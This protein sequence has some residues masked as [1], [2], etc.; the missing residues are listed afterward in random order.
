MYRDWGKRCFDATAAAAG[1]LCLAPVMALL[2]LLVRV[3]LGSPV[4]FRQERPGLGGRGFTI[5]KFR[6]MA[7]A[8]DE[9]GAL[10]PDADRLTPFGRFLRSSS[11]DELPELINVLKGEMSLVG[12]RP[13]LVCYLVR[14]SAE[15]AR[16]HGVR[17]GITGWAQVGG[18]N[19]LGWDD[20]LARDVWYV[21]HVGLALDLSILWK[22]AGA[23]VSRRG[24]SAPGH[25]TMPEFQGSAL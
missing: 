13:L 2:A 4:L 7:D 20:R 24:V 16:R 10:R 19:A 11:L 22:T 23:V 6:T 14:Y 18:R 15:Q 21:D 5:L 1:L 3:K 12:P 8:R 25:A 9:S 17:P